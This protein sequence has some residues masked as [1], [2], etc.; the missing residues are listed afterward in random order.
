LRVDLLA[1]WWHRT[2]RGISG[3]GFKPSIAVV[4]QHEGI[5]GARRFTPLTK[6]AI[7]QLG[8]PTKISGLNPQQLCLITSVILSIVHSLVGVLGLATTGRALIASE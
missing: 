2:L 1:V 3:R 8:V 4:A 5:G 7:P 6:A